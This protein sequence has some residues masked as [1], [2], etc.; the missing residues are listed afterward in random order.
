MRVFQFHGRGSCTRETGMSISRGRR[1]S[2]L[3]GRA[4]IGLHGRS[5]FAGFL[6]PDYETLQ[7]N[8]NK[9]DRSSHNIKPFHV[10]QGQRLSDGNRCGLSAGP[11]PHISSPISGDF[12]FSSCCSLVAPARST[13]FRHPKTAQPESSF[14]RDRRSK[15]LAR[16][17]LQIVQDRLINMLNQNLLQGNSF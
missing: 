15:R 10:V 14:R 7:P 8:A 13:G 5:E 16:R 4:G 6:R 2:I 3:F 9:T 12:D 1:R 17:H 11:E